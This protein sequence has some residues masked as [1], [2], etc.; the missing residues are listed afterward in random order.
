MP[1]REVL[2]L[3]TDRELRA[4]LASYADIAPV[5]PDFIEGVEAFARANGMVKSAEIGPVSTFVRLGLAPGFVRVHVNYIGNAVRDIVV[6]PD[7]PPTF[8]YVMGYFDQYPA[9]SIGELPLEL[10]RPLN[11]VEA[12]GLITDLR[13]LAQA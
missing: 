5:N 3:E 7:I 6:I 4:A 1:T 9:A 13:T 2:S 8:A 11:E 12:Q 10:K